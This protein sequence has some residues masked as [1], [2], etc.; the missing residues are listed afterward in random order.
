MWRSNTFSLCKNTFSLKWMN[1]WMLASI[2][3]TKIS[4]LWWTVCFKSPTLIPLQ[5]ISNSPTDNNRSKYVLKIQIPRPLSR[6]IEL[7]P[8]AWGQKLYFHQELQVILA[9]REVWETM[10]RAHRSLA[11]VMVREWIQTVRH[12]RQDRKGKRWLSK[13]LSPF[14]LAWTRKLVV[15]LWPQAESAKAEDSREERQKDP[16]PA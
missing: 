15:N 10:T 12:K 2:V 13:R 9:I 8:P 1:E 14:L 5:W 7:Q 3:P 16:D 6:P 11:T 4:A